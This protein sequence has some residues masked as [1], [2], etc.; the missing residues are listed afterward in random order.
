MPGIKEFMNMQAEETCSGEFRRYVIQI[1]VLSR[2]LMIL[3]TC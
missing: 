1:P 3:K 2:K